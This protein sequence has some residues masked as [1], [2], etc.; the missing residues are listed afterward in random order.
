MGLDSSQSREVHLGRV[1]ER[2]A[3]DGGEVEEIEARAVSH[4]IDPHAEEPLPYVGV[5]EVL[6]LVVRPSGQA[7][8][9]GG[10]LVAQNA[11]EV[12]DGVLLF[13]REPAPLDVGPQIVRPP[14]PAALP[15]PLQ[16]GILRE[17]PPVAVAVPL[18]VVDQ[19]LVLLRR[20]RAFLEP[21]LVATRRPSH[22]FHVLSF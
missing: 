7:G 20:P 14:Q 12:N 8:G 16:P 9:D 1:V 11:M 22:L 21:V 10:P 3:Q 4:G 19:L 15:A 18:D 13:E 17:G 2:R 6:D 5:P